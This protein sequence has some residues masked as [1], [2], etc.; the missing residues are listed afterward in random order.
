M[1]RNLTN[2]IRTIMDDWLPPVIRDSRWFMYPF[3]YFWY[4][5]DKP[6][7]DAYMSF[8]SNVYGWSKA[9]YE[10]FYINKRPKSRAASR[11]TDLNAECVD[12]MLTHFHPEASTILDVGCGNGFF[13]H[14]VA[15]ADTPHHY[16][17]HACD[18]MESKSLG[19]RITYHQGNI[20]S[21]PFADKSFDIVTCH[22]TIEHIPNPHR[23]VQELKRVARKQV[24]LVTPCQRYYYYTLDEHVNFFPVG[25]M[26][27][28][29]MNS[30]ETG[31]PFKQHQCLHL[32]GDWMYD[33]RLD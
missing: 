20:E 10:D 29:L 18:V 8:K 31:V 30:T 16:A 17:L 26:L 28:H 13:L 4:N 15:A 25:S 19:E 33:G 32:K 24:L 5:G 12:Y 11:P 3:F 9:E 22:H 1:N 27:E 6:T 7:I 2:A 14:Q 23:A 21:L